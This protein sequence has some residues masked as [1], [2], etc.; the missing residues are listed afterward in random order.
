MHTLSLHRAKHA[1]IELDDR[2]LGMR[3][4]K[5]CGSPES[6]PIPKHE[7][8][9]G[10]ADHDH[11]RAELQYA[12]LKRSGHMHQAAEHPAYRGT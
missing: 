12:R 1:G 8:E 10:Q 7:E 2:K 11:S 3:C 6:Y 9:Q 4:P 5:M